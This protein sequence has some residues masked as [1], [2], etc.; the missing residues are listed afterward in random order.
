M[1]LCFLKIKKNLF[2]KAFGA[3]LFVFFLFPFLFSKGY[4]SVGNIFFGQVP[5]LYNV[6]LAQYFFTYASYP[7]FGDP[8]PYAHY[9]LSRT[10][11]IQ[12]EF[13][14]AIHEAQVELEFYPEHQRTHYILGLTY[15]YMNE[16]EKAIEEFSK[17]IE[18]YPSTWAGRNDKAWLQFRIGDIDGA[19]ETI[20]PV[21]W[22]INNP[23]VQNMYGVVLMNKGNRNEALQ[24]FKYAQAATDAMS[25]ESW[26]KAY[27][28]ND[29]RIY[30]TGLNAMKQSIE[31]NL[32]LLNE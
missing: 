14:D 17:F 18:V 21:I 1:N 16:E 29:P 26:G 7:L 5:T 10:Y 27:P 32:R 24:A 22:D 25:E 20:K 15:G 3:F 2:L 9:Q 4:F 23:W 13:D 31:A 12:G 19:Y 11:F 30:E 6:N 8:A 28:G